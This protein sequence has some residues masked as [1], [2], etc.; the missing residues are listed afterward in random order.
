MTTQQLKTNLIP[1]NEWETIKSLKENYSVVIKLYCPTRHLSNL[2]DILLKT[3]LI[4][5]KNYIKDNLDFLAKCFRENEWDT[6]LTTFD[7]VGL[8]SNISHKYGL[9]VIEYWLDK[10]PKSLHPRFSKGFALESVIF[11]LENNS[12]NFDN[13]YFN[14]IKGT[15]MGTI[16]ATTYANL[17]RY[18]L[19]S[20]YTIF[21]GINLGKTEEN[22]SLKTGA[23]FSM[24]VKP[25]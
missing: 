2:V 18:F 14:Q 1:Q 11:I 21:P 3:F 10:F 16:F 12:L 4:H 5:I 17:I 20:L 8:C 24:T 9:E 25:Y 19:S 7:V 15:A 23:F 13:E 6:I 22:L